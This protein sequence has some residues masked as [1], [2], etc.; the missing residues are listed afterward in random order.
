MV[1]RK[2]GVSVT[3]TP[4]SR[5][6]SP[7]DRQSTQK[8]R[9]KPSVH[10]SPA[11]PVTPSVSVIS[12][13]PPVLSL[14]VSSCIHS[15]SSSRPSSARRPSTPVPLRV[16]ISPAKARS[17]DDSTSAASKSQPLFQPIEKEQPQPAKAPPPD[18]WFK[19]FF[20][21]PDGPRLR[22][23]CPRCEAP[24]GRTDAPGCMLDCHDVLCH[25]CCEA[26]L[27][28]GQTICCPC[29]RRDTP[30][31]GRTLAQ[32]AIPRVVSALLEIKREE[33][34]AAPLEATLEA[35]GRPLWPKW[36]T[37]GKLPD[38]AIGAWRRGRCARCV[39][40]SSG[41]G[42]CPSSSAAATTCATTAASWS[43]P[44]PAPRPTSSAPS[45]GSSRPTGQT[46]ST[47]S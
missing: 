44:A 42:G 14:E 2:P 18:T 17:S 47:L 3:S 4:G 7:F 5:S 23:V 28:G 22:L 40:R 9:Q 21:R 16:S 39:W 20:L 32:L 27:R 26:L 36:P 10:S 30:L 25:A 29:C 13:K 11:S 6:V 8:L 38:P 37:L 45:A 41:R 19:G 24:T 46:A 35:A 1:M 34:Y 43:R 12:P 33:L 31:A 15:N